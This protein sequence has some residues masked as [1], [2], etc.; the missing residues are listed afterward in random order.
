MVTIANAAEDRWRANVSHVDVAKKDFTTSTEQAESCLT[1]RRRH[2]KA[3]QTAFQVAR[4]SAF[5]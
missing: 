1:R 4:A 5:R 3:N 2:H